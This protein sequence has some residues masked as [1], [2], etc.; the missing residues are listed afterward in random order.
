MKAASGIYIISR[1]SGD[2]YYIGSAINI[3]RR[4]AV[5]RCRLNKGDHHSP[6]LM[7]AWRKHGPSAF[8][9]AV[10]EIVPDTSKL[11]ERE[12]AWLDRFAPYYNTLRIAGSVLGH[13]VSASTRAKISKAHKGRKH[14]PP[15]AET[16]AKLSAAIGGRPLSLAHRAK[17][18]AAKRG[19]T[20]G[21]YSEQ[22]RA[23]IAA[24]VAR[25]WARGRAGG[26]K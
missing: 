24:G 13:E 25:S 2:R 16:R 5:H 14:G 4:W 20:R 8:E 17:L 15:S 1:R 11:L 12:Q 18:A 23:R 19:T 3:C 26:A 10:L 22:H 6:Q 21:T 9:F 7:A